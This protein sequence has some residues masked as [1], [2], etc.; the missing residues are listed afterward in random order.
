M[1]AR[2]TPSL[3]F[4][5]SAPRKTSSTAWI[6]RRWRNSLEEYMRV[7]SCLT[8]RRFLK[9]RRGGVEEALALA[10]RPRRPVSCSTE[11]TGSSSRSMM[12]RPSRFTLKSAKDWTPSLRP[13]SAAQF[14]TSW[15]TVVCTVMG[16]TCDLPS[17]V[18]TRTVLGGSIS[19]PGPPPLVRLRVNGMRLTRLSSNAPPCI[20]LSSRSPGMERESLRSRDLESLRSSAL[21]TDSAGEG[22]DVEMESSPPLDCAV[23]A[24]DVLSLR[25]R[26]PHETL[27]VIFS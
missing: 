13:S 4:T 11:P 12:W 14:F 3:T 22:A 6:K 24:L 2:R 7:S 15:P 27:R 18:N 25:L 5:G 26:L 9:T 16:S 10:R 23:A 17:T 21:P 8:K 19:S 20:S 1:L